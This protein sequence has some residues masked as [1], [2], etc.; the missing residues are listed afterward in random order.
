MSNWFVEW[1]H[2]GGQRPRH[3]SDRGAPLRSTHG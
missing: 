3:S 2:N 1:T